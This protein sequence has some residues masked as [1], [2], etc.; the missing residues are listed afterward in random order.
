MEKSI[1]GVGVNGILL[2]IIDY[3]SSI[4]CREVES[5]LINN[6]YGLS[7]VD[8]RDGDT[9]VDIG[10]NVGIVSIYIA[11]MFPGVK[12]LSFEP[13]L[14]NYGNLVENIKTKEV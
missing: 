4:T 13:I 3:S 1:Q 9:A 10:A 2:D 6:V 5:G 12:V 8:F 11:K 7:D 14:A